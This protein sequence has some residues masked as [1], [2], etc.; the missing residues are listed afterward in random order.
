MYRDYLQT[1]IERDVRQL[2]AIKD[3]SLFQKFLVICAGRV[4]QR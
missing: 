2:S 1:Y 4:G 3:L